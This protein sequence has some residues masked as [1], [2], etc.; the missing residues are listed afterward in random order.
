MDK[1]EISNIGP[2]NAIGSKIFSLESYYGIIEPLII[3]N[4]NSNL[5]PE[6]KARIGTR[7]NLNLNFDFICLLLNDEFELSNLFWDTFSIIQSNN[8]D[9][10]FNFS[11]DQLAQ[12]LEL[13]SASKDKINNGEELYE[14][15]KLFISLRPIPLLSKI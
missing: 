12:L 11:L 7:E 10:R 9:Q 8:I 5:L 14:D 2:F 6:N 4:T 3:A 1:K 13:T 15:L